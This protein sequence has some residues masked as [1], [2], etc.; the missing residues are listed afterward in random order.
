[1]RSIGR[2]AH[3]HVRSLAV[4]LGVLVAATTVLSACG[5]AIVQQRG[6]TLAPLTPGISVQVNVVLDDLQAGDPSGATARQEACANVVQASWVHGAG[7][8]L[9]TVDGSGVHLVFSTQAKASAVNQTF[10]G[11]RRVAM[12]SAMLSAFR[13]VDAERSGTQGTSNLIA[14]LGELRAELRGF[15]DGDDQVLVMSTGLLRAPLDLASHPQLLADPN[16][17]AKALARAGR[18]PDLHGFT[19][20][21]QTAGLISNK[22]SLDLMALWWAILKRAGGQL[23]GFQQAVLSWPLSAMPQPPVPG[24]IEMQTTPGRVIL[25][26]PDRVLFDVDQASIRADAK[27]VIAELAAILLRRY[28][29]ASA[30]INGYTDDTGSAA[31][32]RLLSQARARSVAAALRSAGVAAR[33]LT[34]LGHGASRFVAA[35]TTATGRQENRRVE[36]VIRLS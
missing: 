28:P 12:T 23:S 19:V 14:A 20:A 13:K 30:T 9:P 34:A 2:H 31:W 22:R 1:M 32:N 3:M 8:V 10:A 4:A 16:G 33:R 21:I 25:R 6:T 36:I 35:N 27:P 26:V 5:P 18:L 29:T 24:A 17:T 15:G 7:L 11:M